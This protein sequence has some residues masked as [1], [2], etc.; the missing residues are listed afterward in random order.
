[1]T[2]EGT[3]V[4]TP[5]E[6]ECLWCKEGFAEGDAGMAIPSGMDGSFVYY[7]KD[8]FLRTILGSLGHQRKQCSC[9]GG[10]LED[11]QGVSLREAAT[12]AVREHEEVSRRSR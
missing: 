2:A 6:N 9:F 7:H 10:T 12:L 1:M 5:V 4:P 11:P 3:Q 8:C